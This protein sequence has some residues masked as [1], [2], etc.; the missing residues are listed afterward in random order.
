MR[1]GDVLEA[2]EEGGEVDG[3]RHVHLRART[4]VS[5]E[6]AASQLSRF[7]PP[8]TSSTRN[9]ATREHG[10]E[11]RA[12][13]PLQDDVLSGDDLDR[14]LFAG[15]PAERRR[16]EED[17]A[18]GARVH[19]A[20]E[21]DPLGVVLADVEREARHALVE[22]PVVV[23]DLEEDRGAR[24]QEAGEVREEPGHL[25][26]RR[27]AAG[28]CRARSRRRRGRSRPRRARRDPP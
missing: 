25:H 21:D 13:P 20:E 6:V 4:T 9:P 18:V 1:C 10:L 24:K 2:R 28:R 27:G 14:R 17:G 12:A 7:I 11:L 23:E 3:L 19:E 26:R 16:V 22:D 8:K 15:P 5:D